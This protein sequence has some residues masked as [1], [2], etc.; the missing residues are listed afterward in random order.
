MRESS[1]IQLP[2]LIR[3]AD[4]AQVDH[5]QEWQFVVG[6]CRRIRDVGKPMFFSRK[7]FAMTSEFAE[8]LQNDEIHHLSREDQQ[9]ALHCIRSIIFME[10][11]ANGWRNMLQLPHRLQGFPQLKRVDHVF[12][13]QFQDT[14]DVLMR[15]SRSRRKPSPRLLEPLRL[16]EVPVDDLDMGV[17][18]GAA[19]LAKYNESMLEGCNYHNLRFFARRKKRIVDAKRNQEMEVEME[20]DEQ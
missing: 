11:Y 16:L 15:Q 10:T 17:I 20:V 9:M 13:G 6:T 12:G 3:S 4:V 2:L 5:L 8:K 19:G 1:L 18:D 7:T 14:F